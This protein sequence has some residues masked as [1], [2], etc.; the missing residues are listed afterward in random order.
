ML[1]LRIPIVNMGS[2]E[3]G[4]SIELVRVVCVDGGKIVGEGLGDNHDPA[5]V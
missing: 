3:Q 1:E 5:L 2:D 4:V